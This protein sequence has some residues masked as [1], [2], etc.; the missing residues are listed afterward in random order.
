MLI[1]S[2]KWCYL[3]WHTKNMSLKFLMWSI[4]LTF[5]SRHVQGW[6]AKTNDTND[7]NEI[8]Y[9][10]ITYPQ[11]LQDF[12]PPWFRYLIC[13]G[14]TFVIRQELGHCMH[15]QEYLLFKCWLWPLTFIFSVSQ[16]NFFYSENSN[17]CKLIVWSKINLLIDE[18]Y[19][20][21]SESFIQ[22]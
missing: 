17:N 12:L 1:F 10:L 18:V 15:L 11:P 2:V 21:S 9:F 16:S 22:M 8:F 7:T 4:A 13:M 20:I 5:D 3:V 6:T 14:C 19:L